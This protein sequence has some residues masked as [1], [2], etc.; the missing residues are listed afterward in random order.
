M[1]EPVQQGKVMVMMWIELAISQNMVVHLIINTSLQIT[2]KF[3]PLFLPQKFLPCPLK[4]LPPLPPPPCGI[5]NECRFI[6]KHT[7]VINRYVFGVIIHLK[8]K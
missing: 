6:A 8:I 4:F 5:H 7:V 1:W 3:L 2:S